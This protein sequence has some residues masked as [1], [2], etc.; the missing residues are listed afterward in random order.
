MRDHAHPACLIDRLHHL[1]RRRRRRGN[2]ILAMRADRIGER[3]RTRGVHTCRHQ[4]VGDVWAPDG[5]VA[6]LLDLCQHIIPRDRVIPRQQRHHALD[7]FEARGPRRHEQIADMPVAWIVL[8]RQHVHGD[9]AVLCCDLRT[10]HQRQPIVHR[11]LLGLHPAGRRVV[12]SDRH[13][14]QP[15]LFRLPN[16]GPGRLGSIGK[17]GMAV[18]VPAMGRRV[19]GHRWL[20]HGSHPNHWTPQTVSAS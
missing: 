4:G 7:P 8:V 16:Q 2:V 19:H 13:A 3:I 15:G 11:R 17:H 12:V 5:G 6:A 18:Q 9:A 10:A 14:M 1:R 20:V